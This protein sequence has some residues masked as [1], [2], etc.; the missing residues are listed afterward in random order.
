MENKVDKKSTAKDKKVNLKTASAK[1][2]KVKVEPVEAKID[3]KNL[4][5]ETTKD[6]NIS[7]MF[8]EIAYKLPVPI[9]PK[10]DNVIGLDDVDKPANNGCKC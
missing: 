9:L 8:D 7:K 10:P 1:D 3:L 6:I 4:K 2:A 5:Y